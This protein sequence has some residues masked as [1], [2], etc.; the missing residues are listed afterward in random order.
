M[1][2]IIALSALWALIP[3]A[4]S[5][6]PLDGYEP[7]GITRLLAYDRA[8]QALLSRGTLVPG[9]LKTTQQVRL[10]LADRPGFTLP[11]AD[12]EFGRQI[13][14]LLGAD[15]S[16]YGV[17]VLDL[18]DPANPR[19]AAWRATVAQQPGSLGKIAVVLAFFD[20]LADAYP[21]DLE[22]RARI[23]RE[24]Q[25]TAN[26]Y[27]GLDE[28]H[29]VP[30]YNPGDQQLT[31]RLLEEGDRANVY[32]YLDWMISRSSNAAAA[33]VQYHLIL[34]KH[35]GR[36]YPVSEER[37]KAFFAKSSGAELQRIY[38]SAMM[39]ALK[40]SG[41]DPGEFRQGSF[42]SRPGRQR[43]PS[44]GS[45]CTAEGLMRYL[46]AMERGKLVDPWSSL[47]IKRLL[48][49]TD[50]RIRYAASPTLNDS[51][52]YY[53]SGSMFK[54]QPEAGFVC[55]KFHGNRENIMNSVAVVETDAKGRSLNYLVVVL[56]D[57]LRKDSAQ[58]HQDFATDVHRVIESSHAR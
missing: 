9:A 53:K 34:L 57:V 19:Y 48:Y 44:I 51:A 13:R 21:A 50:R 47:E 24:T 2:R 43:V 55:E 22:A 56:S 23:L 40:G 31:F 16:R 49:L 33:M 1:N 41:L 28:A 25:I 27:I 29:K 20:A 4:A 3:V 5:G 52:V 30:F 32:T 36:E 7:T 38:S 8:R 42:F 12:P 17:A 15:A 39:S 18:S 58:V 54:C 45:T 37:A 10:L 35:F 6:Y 46:V 11:D 14:M 26:D